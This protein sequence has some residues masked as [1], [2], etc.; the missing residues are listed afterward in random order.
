M[1]LALREKGL[2]KW[3][4]SKINLCSVRCHF[5]QRKADFPKLLK[6]K[7]QSR[8]HVSV[9]VKPSGLHSGVQGPLGGPLEGQ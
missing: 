3:K 6:A 2:N 1:S 4:A 7:Q 8:R 9:A 5:H